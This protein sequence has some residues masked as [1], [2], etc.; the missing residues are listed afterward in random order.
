MSIFRPIF[1]LV[2][3]SVLKKLLISRIDDLARI[4]DDKILHQIHIKK[5]HKHVSL[6]SL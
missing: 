1:R 6:T 2:F 4:K 5:I 3:C